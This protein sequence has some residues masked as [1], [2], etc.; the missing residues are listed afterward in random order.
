VTRFANP[1]KYCGASSVVIDSTGN[2]NPAP[3]TSAMS[4]S[5]TPSCDP[6]LSARVVHLGQPHHHPASALGDEGVGRLLGGCAE[7]LGRVDM[8]SVST[9]G[10][11]V[12]DRARPAGDD[13]ERPVRDGQHLTQRLDD[14]AVV[15]AALL[16]VGQVVVEGRVK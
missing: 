14:L 15:L 4:R 11:P 5:A 6:A 13:D 2:F 9:A 16:Q 7:E 12:F 3:I 8:I 1:P 10:A